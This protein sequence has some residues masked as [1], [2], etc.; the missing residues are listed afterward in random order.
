M[1]GKGYKA[2][3]S[4]DTTDVDRSLEELKKEIN[5][6]TRVINQ[7]NKAGVSF[8]EMYKQKQEE[9]G[10][11]IEKTEE[12]LK[13]LKDAE[14]QMKQARAS[15]D[16]S[17]NEYAAYRRD[18]AS[19]EASLQSYRAELSRT[20]QAGNELAVNQRELSAAIGE[21]KESA[22]RVISDLSSIAKVAGA[23]IGAVGVGAAALTKEAVESY[24]QYEQMIGGIETLFKEGSE[25]VE[26]YAAD[27][28]R[29]AQMSANDYMEIATSFAARLSQGLG[30]DMEKAAELTDMAITDMADNVAKLGTTMAS[31]QNAYQGIMRQNYTMI[32][33]LKI[34]YGGTQS[35]MARLIN[36]SGVL[37]DTVKV[38][39]QTLNTVSFDKMIEAIHKVQENLGIT[40]TTAYEAA[41]TIQ[42][43]FGSLSAAWQNLVTGFANSEQDF[44]KL[45]D[46]VV[47]S[48]SGILD[49]ITP[50]IMAALPRIEEG[51]G[52]LAERVLPIAAE[53]L[54]GI[55]NELFSKLNI[56]AQEFVPALT[57]G[58]N[59]IIEGLNWFI[60]N[61]DKVTV[62]VKGLGV[63]WLSWKIGS[64]VSDVYNLI[65]SFVSY[66]QVAAT[67]TAEQRALNAT[68][69]ANLIIAVA[70]AVIGLANAITSYVVSVQKANIEQA[71]LNTE[72]EQAY[73]DITK[74]IQ[75]FADSEKAAEDKT[76]AV[77]KLLDKLGDMVDENGN[78]LASEYSVSAV[79]D[80]VNSA[81]GTHMEVVN[82]MVVGYDE[83]SGSVD[84]YLETLKRQAKLEYYYDSYKEAI[85]TIDEQTEATEKARKEYNATQVELGHVNDE[86]NKLTNAPSVYKDEDGWHVVLSINSTK[87]QDDTAFKKI[88]EIEELEKR[89]ETLEKKL[90]DK[91]NIWAVN[92]VRQRELEN[93]ITD[94]EELA[95]G[96]VG[97]DE[98]GMTK[99]EAERYAK[100]KEAEENREKTKA[101][102]E[103][104]KEEL[105]AELEAL[106]KKKKLHKD[107][108]EED[109][110][111]YREKAKILK[112]YEPYMRESEDYWSAYDDVANYYGK[113]SDTVSTSSTSGSTV[114][115]LNSEKTYSVSELEA[116][117]KK[118]IDTLNESYEKGLIDREVYNEK[119]AKLQNKWA[120]NGIDITEYAEKEVESVREKV[121]KSDFDAIAKMYDEGLITRQEFNTAYAQLE[122]EWSEDSISIA[123]YTAEKISEINKE[124]IAKYNSDL[125][126][127]A[128][129]VQ[130]V[131]DELAS[132]QQQ[133][134]D[135]MTSES[136][137]DTVSTTDGERP[138]FDDLSKRAEEIN[139]YAADYA[140]LSQMEGVPAD[141]LEEIKSMSFDDRRAVVSELIKMSEKNRQTYFSDYNAYKN[142]AEAAAAVETADQSA[143]A[144]KYAE[145]RFADVFA[146]PNNAYIAG[147]SMGAEWIK[148][149]AE[150]LSGSN[151]MSMLGM[152]NVFEYAQNLLSSQTEG[153]ISVK[154]PIVINLGAATIIETTIYDILRG[155]GLV[156]RENSRL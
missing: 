93:S 25:A 10:E 84:D 2:K 79:L 107:G 4:L 147:Q 143:E 112:K 114:T 135:S 26:S 95:G 131:Y 29:T 39:A 77:T 122:R 89:K 85:G 21:V 48:A 13:R 86:L 103:Q 87:G 1:A 91:E 130:K 78:L 31:V 121:A 69:N 101:F 53:A 139:Q 52:K 142:A 136:L 140:K 61:L 57:E 43:S 141:L 138:I 30:G 11:A 123:E 14:E 8:A 17:E 144:E 96:S 76:A 67:A 145:D 113:D 108:M 74:E 33:N 132:A 24:G 38:T 100:Q 3:I 90:Q 102:Q 5:A 60:E 99:E 80:D 127:A 109:E 126:A 97:T 35:E 56:S 44:D 51:I 128:D 54:D 46:D 148:G 72:L 94:Y 153:A 137:F 59:G 58:I 152:S 9:L 15:G 118:E 105:A 92:N 19:T 150:E 66:I 83:L 70:S 16:V 154:T 34:G 63:A 110:N 124:Q 40:G 71:L 50:R 146:D 106:D 82:G 28:F 151:V 12:R 20:E 149:F 47:N 6:T 119:Y 32:D 64:L 116:N 133:A 104:K 41:Q 37:G 88:K 45:I 98:N 22:G 65:S 68:M 55:I 134:A 42:G 49:N 156:G 23:A 155:N 7:S 111:Y 115:A 125:E 36:D 27:A 75:A 62:A 73:L 129:D 18:I 117:A 81:L 120:E